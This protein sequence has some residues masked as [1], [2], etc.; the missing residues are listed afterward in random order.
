VGV[1]LTRCWVLR[2]R[3]A[4]VRAGVPRAGVVV[5]LPLVVPGPRVVPDP[6]LLE[7]DVLARVGVCGGAGCLGW[8][9]SYVE[10]CTVDASI[11]VALSF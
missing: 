3:A 5:W 7:L 6:R 9:W 2:D 4:F 10:N 1:V 11:F 8:A